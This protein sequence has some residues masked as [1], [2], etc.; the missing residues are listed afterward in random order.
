MLYVVY[1][2]E[3]GHIG[4]YVSHDHPKH[5]THPIFGLGGFVLPASQVRSF[6]TFFFQLKNKMFENFDIPQAQKKA[7]AKGNEFHIAKWEKKGSQLYSV[8][9]INKYPLVKRSTNRIINRINKD[10]GFTFFV[11]EAKKQNEHHDPQRTYTSCLQEVIK[12]LN[13]E[14]IKSNDQFL[15]V[16]DEHPDRAKIVEAA[17]ITMFA[18]SKFSIIEAPFQVESHLYQTIQCADWLC[19]IYGKIS[20]F[21][22][23]PKVKHDYECFKKYFGERIQQTQ[24]RSSIRNSF[25]DPSDDQLIKLQNKYNN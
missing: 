19:A 10:G 20:Y 1:L 17:C 7:K 6:S 4:P 21:D 8:N 24:K 14:F 3:F 18:D 13:N 11:G 9:N 23:E 12:R 15:I 5:K 16:I 22:C 2:D 25:K